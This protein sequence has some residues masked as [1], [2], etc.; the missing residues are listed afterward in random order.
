MFNRCRH[1]CIGQVRAEYKKSTETAS[2]NDEITVNDIL[3]DLLHVLQF[4][5]DN[6]VDMH[7]DG[8][9][10]ATVLQAQ[11]NIGNT[12]LLDG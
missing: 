9:D 2:V 6:V 5:V 3:P 4:A 12:R 8:T 1:G 10:V 7:A 11:A